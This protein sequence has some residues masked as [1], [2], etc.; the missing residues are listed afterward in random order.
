M[1]AETPSVEKHC[2][3]QGPHLPPPC[4]GCPAARGESAG[5]EGKVGG[6]PRLLGVV[7][8]LVHL[9]PHLWQ[10]GSRA[11]QTLSA[12]LL[13]LP[14][15]VQESRRPLPPAR[16]RRFGPAAFGSSAQR[17]WQLLR[18]QPWRAEGGEAHPTWWTQ[19]L[20]HQVRANCGSS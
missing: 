19:V 16:P 10:R 13:P 3:N 9:L 14:A 7:G 17:R 12:R 1:V 6:A 11:E 15:L 20:Q 4:T 5:A 8:G 2:S 18:R